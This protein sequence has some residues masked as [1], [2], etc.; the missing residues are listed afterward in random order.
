MLRAKP[1]NTLLQLEKSK[2]RIK[3][4]VKLIRM[5]VNKPTT[6]NEMITLLLMSQSLIPKRNLLWL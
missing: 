3:S 5:L 2:L 1:W 6:S 4:I